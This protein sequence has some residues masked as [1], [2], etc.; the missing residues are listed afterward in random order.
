MKTLIDLYLKQI[1]VIEYITNSF[2]Y[3]K[4]D[5]W[6][7]TES[8]MWSTLAHHKLHYAKIEEVLALF[9]R[10]RHPLLCLDKNLSFEHFEKSLFSQLLALL[11]D[12]YQQVYVE[13][14]VDRGYWFPV[15]VLLI[16]Q[17]V[18]HTLVVWFMKRL[19]QWMIHINYFLVIMVF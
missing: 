14:C 8:S 16:K 10:I 4:N 5:Y 18:V 17:K 13:Y 19:S 15:K 7:V 3:S 9:W 6:S 2:L 11:H 1:T 12:A